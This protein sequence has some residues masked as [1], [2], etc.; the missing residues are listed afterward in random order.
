MNKG[1]LKFLAAVLTTG[2]LVVPFLG[3]DDLPRGLRQQIDAEQKAYTEARATFQRARSEVN[4][5]LESDPVLFRAHSMNMVFP[6]RFRKA[7]TT[8]AAADRDMAA[9]SALRKA[10]RRGDRAQAERLLPQ[11]TAEHKAALSEATGMRAEAARWVE[12]KRN[13]PRQIQQMQAD[14]QALRAADLSGV[15]AVVQKAQADWPEKKA[16]LETRL[17]ALRAMPAEAEKTWLASEPLRKQ[18]AAGDYA[19]L[20]YAAL[21]T[22]AE[23]LH[24]Q[25]TSLLPAKVQELK[26][27]SAQLYD[28]WD[29]LLVDLD[30]RGEDGGRGYR[31]KVRTV[32]THWN[33][34]SGKSANVATDERW[35]PVSGAEYAA[36][37]K[38]LGMAVEHKPAG[39]Y[40]FESEKTAQP[41]GFAYMAP[42]G[43][44]NQ[45]GRWENRGGQS[46]WVFYGQY[47]LMRDLLFNRDYRPLDTREYQSYRTA[48]GSGQTYYG[49]DTT[50]DA[51]RYGTQGTATQSRYSGSTYAQSGGFKDS[52]YATRGGGYKDSKYATRGYKEHPEEA[53]P[54]QFG[55][56]SSGSMSR[57]SSPPSR[58]WS[59]PPRSSRPSFGG[60]S[61]GRRFG[62]GG[63]R[64]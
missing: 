31:E 37:E 61:G 47:A 42:P 21:L 48:Q 57:P 56:G 27:L 1:G 45:Y 8:L 58:S 25:A 5:D 22:A 23:T 52:Q 13:L 46:F 18:A 4:R 60:S 3:L 59:P 12:M 50:T 9:L 39:K 33:D 26:G 14:Y 51:P 49:R 10:N 44:A 53:A 30:R 38:N 32:R 43:Q 2:V 55:G 36:V 19:N 15:A 63:R 16:D 41:A 54:R 64:R 11:V 35:V 20:D 29:K 34:A 28:S 24:N 40:D 6:E 17:V 62:G 7:E